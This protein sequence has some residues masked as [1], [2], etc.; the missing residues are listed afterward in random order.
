MSGRLIGP[1]TQ[2]RIVEKCG[3]RFGQFRDCLGDLCDN[4]CNKL[5][6]GCYWAGNFHGFR[7]HKVELILGKW[8]A[9]GQPTT[10]L[11]TVKNSLSLL[12]WTENGPCVL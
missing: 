11:G 1:K 6:F 12:G 2:D 9:H 7:F 4:L 3:T 10:R 5:W 8:A